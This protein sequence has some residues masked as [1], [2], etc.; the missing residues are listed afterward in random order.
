MATAQEGKTAAPAKLQKAWDS[1]I[2]AYDIVENYMGDGL[3]LAILPTPKR[4]LYSK[5]LFAFNQLSIVL[6]DNYP[7]KAT[8]RDLVKLFPK[9]KFLTASNFKAAP[10]KSAVIFVGN[11]SRNPATKAFL[12]KADG[13]LA[14]Q[15]A[16]VT[17]T[18]GYQLAVLPGADGGV[19]VVIS[20]NKAAGDFWAVQTLGQ[21]LIEKQ[22]KR[23]LHGIWTM[24]WPSFPAR[25]SKGARQYMPQYKDNFSWGGHQDHKA[26]KENFGWYIPYWGP[27]AKLDCSTA[28]LDQ[29]AE[30]F[31]THFNRGVRNFCIKFD[32]VGADLHSGFLLRTGDIL[33]AEDLCKIL[34]EAAGDEND[35]DDDLELLDDD[36]KPAKWV[37]KSLDKKTHGL[38]WN[39]VSRKNFS[40]RARDGL[41]AGLN[42]ILENNSFYSKEQFKGI[43]LSASVKKLLAQRKTLSKELQQK[44]N[45]LLLQA[46]FPKHFRPCPEQDTA[47][48]FKTYGPAICYFMRE[49]DKRVKAFS[50]DCRLFYLSQVYGGTRPNRISKMI[51]AG[52]GL[53]K[54]VSLCWTGP[55]GASTSMHLREDGIKG[56]MAAYKSTEKGIIYDNYLRTATANSGKGDFGD[57]FALP[58]D[59]HG[60]ELTKHLIGVF[61]E[62]SDR[63][64]RMTRCDWNWNPE[65]YDEKR[66][67]K[68]AI[69]EIAGPKA[70]K[71]ML[72]FIENLEFANPGRKASRFFRTMFVSNQTELN[73]KELKVLVDKEK[74][75]IP[76]LLATLEKHLPKTKA[77]E[78]LLKEW[79]TL[80]ATRVRVGDSVL[81]V[82]KH[83]RTAKARRLEGKISIDG[84]PDEAA[85]KKAFELKDFFKYGQAIPS[86]TKT[87]ARF[88]YDDKFLY[89]SMI[90]DAPALKGAVEKNISRRNVNDWAGRVRGKEQTD[91]IL[92]SSS[93]GGGRVIFAVNSD[94]DRCDVNY[95]NS[96]EDFILGKRSGDFASGWQVKVARGGGQW[97][98]EMALPLKKLTVSRKKLAKPGT[99]WMF[100]IYRRSD[101]IKSTWGLSMDKHNHNYFVDLVFE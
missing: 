12:A 41:L 18:E 17:G 72:A 68:L 78:Q 40:A 39:A 5:R 9:A 73:Y 48:R 28:Y 45:R 26:L 69:R 38:L 30:K 50:P 56:Y 46:A 62:N 74:A 93:V 8:R 25:G 6:P 82:K 34:V 19:R 101:R 98:V 66:A 11:A 90:M 59:G 64:S 47:T 91:L 29:L 97:S 55:A 10:A 43:K 88:L 57:Y 35:D 94:G 86:K 83:W 1:G 31:K 67:L 13:V 100:N 14:A 44:L 49:L 70:Y 20:G 32:D 53:P 99:S 81:L 51:E 3:E 15:D 95:S 65:A 36:E 76:T 37:S 21:C 79:K 92:N 61:S 71:A 96:S 33:K 60:P 84:L 54:D 75:L 23:Y 58:R 24:D 52:G 77:N 4:V 22:G 42:K 85:W 80:S 63:I 89:I 87:S 7:H 27:G 16:A 2:S